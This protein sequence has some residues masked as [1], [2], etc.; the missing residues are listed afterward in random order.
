MIDDLKPNT[1]YEFTVKI[2]KG[3]RQQ[4]PW[5]LVVAN[6]TQEAAPMSPPR[7]LNIHI[8]NNKGS[9]DAGE[10]ILTWRAPKFPNGKINGYVIQYTTNRKAEDREWFVEA[11]VGEVTTATITNLE[12]DTKYY[13][14]IS[15]RNN[16]GYGP[17]SSIVAFTTSG[18]KF[19]HTFEY[20]LIFIGIHLFNNI[21]IRSM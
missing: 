4:S 11:V 13:A 12:P 19:D 10:V 8:T 3:R 9:N 1:E 16:K 15:A 17:Y 6:R 21:E 18:G 5:S 2:I 14:K 20:I 7:D